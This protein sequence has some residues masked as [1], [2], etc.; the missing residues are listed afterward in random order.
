MKSV[1]DPDRYEDNVQVQIR[2]LRNPYLP[3]EE[4]FK[5]KNYTKEEIELAK[6][7]FDFAC[8]YSGYINPFKRKIE[9]ND[10]DSLHEG[11][12]SFIESG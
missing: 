3:S 12:G 5:E 9:I 8:D 10:D 4:I 7:Q 11:S 2:W 1:V 6:K